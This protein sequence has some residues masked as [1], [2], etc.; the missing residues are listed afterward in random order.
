[1]VKNKLVVFDTTLRDGEQSPGVTLTIQEKLEIAK[2]LS[3][4][5]VDVCEA[6]ITLL[7]KGISDC[8]ARGF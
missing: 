5:G 8:I 1:M 4:L 7:K 6:V 2:Q 3:R